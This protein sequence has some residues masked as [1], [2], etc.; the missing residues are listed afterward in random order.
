MAVL[1]IVDLIKNYG[2]VPA[3]RGISL[4]VNDGELVCILGPS[5]CGKST[6]LRIVGGFEHAEGGDV[7]LDGTS[8][9]TL[10]PNRRPTAMV[11]QKYTLWPHMRVYDNVAFGLRLRHLDKA[12]IERKVGDTLELVGLPQARHRYPH[13]L[14]GG[15]QQRI[16]LARALVLEPQVLLLDEPL[17]NLDARLRVRM[18]E[19]IKRIQQRVG[20][21]SVFVTH[22][23]EEALSIAD[24]IAV[25]H[26][27]RLEQVDTPAAVY[28]HPYSLFV[29]DFIGRMNLFEATYQRERKALRVGA[30]VLP[31]PAGAAWPNERTLTVAIRPEDLRPIGE[32]GPTTFSGQVEVVMDLGHYRQI[33][34]QAPPLGLLTMVVGKDVNL[35]SGETVTVAPVRYLVYPGRAGQQGEI[36]NASS[37]DVPPPEEVRLEAA[38][39]TGE[40]V[41]WP[42]GT[43]G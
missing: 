22:D 36:V 14:S 27:G 29:A 35:A 41:R 34:V 43:P 16:A 26:R 4:T 28:D 30:A 33:S 10:P 17:S 15:E 2:P 40:P 31:A 1:A 19:E 12:T 37:A 23:Q 32:P 39:P 13:Q 38:A 9:I 11:F 21:T 5:G 6:T 42:S 24:R 7:R 25:M 20:I 18:R 3:V 8:I